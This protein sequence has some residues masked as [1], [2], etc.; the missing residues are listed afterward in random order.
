MQL[1]EPWFNDFM[2]FS[3][4]GSFFEIDGTEEAYEP[5]FEVDPEDGVPIEVSEA[6]EGY[7]FQ[8]LDTWEAPG[9]VLRDQ[10]GDVIGFYYKFSSWVDPEHRGQGLGALMILA[11]AEHYKDHAWELER[12][13]FNG[14]TGF[15]EAGYSI[16]RQA[17]GMAEHKYGA[18]LSDFSDEGLGSPAP[19]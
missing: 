5:F 4:V 8:S 3:F 7:K 16:H 12:E 2:N 15:S 9:V 14:G 11:Y 17:I 1:L 10:A 18:A 13:E 19:L 6:P